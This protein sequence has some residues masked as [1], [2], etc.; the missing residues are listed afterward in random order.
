MNRLRVIGLLVLVMLSVGAWLA[1]RSFAPSTPQ[2][3]P[4]PPAEREAFHASKPLRIVVS[5][6]T[7]PASNATSSTVWLERELRYLIARGKMRISPLGVEPSAAAKEFTLRV[8]LSAN[9]S[10]AELSLLAPDQV[11]ERSEVVAITPDSYLATMQ[12]LAQHLPTFLGA[13]RSDTP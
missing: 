3:A 12:S 11:V 1:W 8:N 2:P 10:Q 7:D 4:T 9:R 13:P 5:A 6:A